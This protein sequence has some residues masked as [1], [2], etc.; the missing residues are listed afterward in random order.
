MPVHKRQKKNTQNGAYSAGV[1]NEAIITPRM[2]INILSVNCDDCIV[3]KLKFA[4]LKIL[5]NVIC[6]IAY[7]ILINMSAL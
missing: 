6:E 7:A 5:G 3:I 4:F 1:H 2:T